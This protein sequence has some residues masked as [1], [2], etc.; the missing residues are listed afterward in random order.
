MR[1][2]ACDNGERVPATRSRVAERDGCTALVLGVPVEECPAC[3][4][5]W[6]TSEVAGRLDVLFDQL[7]G[8]GAELAHAHWGAPQAA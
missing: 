8:S 3:G 1:C 4:Q 2:D 5:I 6:L 7:L